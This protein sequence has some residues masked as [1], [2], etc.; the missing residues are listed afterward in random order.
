MNIIDRIRS[1]GSKRVVYVN[2]EPSL[3]KQSFSQECDINVIMARFEKTGILSSENA[4]TPRY[5]DFSDVIDYDE[6]LRVVMEADEAFMSLPAKVRARFEN[7]PSQLIEF[8]RDP[9]NVDEAV[10]LGLMEPVIAASSQLPNSSSL[11]VT[12]RT[13]SESP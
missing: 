12:V 13:D 6:S 9:A 7:D 8:V 5:G 2:D 1:N 4:Q 10:S 3:T 11:D